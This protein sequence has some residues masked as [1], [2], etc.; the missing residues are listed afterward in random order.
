ME[1]SCIHILGIAPYEGMRTIML[2]AAE[3]YPNIHLDVAIGDLDEGV[4]IVQSVPEDYYDCIISRG[5]T[6]QRIRQVSNT[7][8]IEIKLSIYD[9][10]RSIKLAENYGGK[11]AVVGFPSIT[12][13]AHILCDLLRYKMDILTI[14]NREDVQPALSRLRADGYQM[15]VGDMVTHTIA[16][17]MGMDAFLITSGAEGL[18]SA[19]EQAITISEAFRRLRMENVVLRGIVQDDVSAVVLDRTGTVRYALPANPNAEL[20]TALRSRLKEIP[21]ERS[22]TF[23]YKKQHTLYSI[24]ARKRSLFD[25]ECTTFYCR[26]GHIPL[27][28]NS[29]GIRS[30]GKLECEHLFMNSFYSL[31][32]AMGEIDETV[33]ALARSRQSV[34]IYG[35]MGTGKEQIAKALYL[36]GTQTNMPFVVFNCKLMTEKSWSF[37]LNHPNSP[38][39]ES[40]GT[41]YFQHLDV[42]PTERLVQL[43]S[44]IQETGMG[45]RLRLIFSCT[46]SAMG[47]L[48]E[49]ARQ[50]IL[51]LGC[52]TVHMPALRARSDEI[53][54]LAS[55]YLNSLNQE[56]GKQISGF[57]PNAIAQLCHYRWPN[58]YT[59]FKHVLHE[60]AVL[61]DSNYIRSAL[62][63][64]LLAKEATLTGAPLVA[65]D[66]IPLTGTLEQITQAVI[67]QA[68]QAHGGNQSAA[69]RQLG[70]GRTTLWRYLSKR[71]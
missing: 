51:E 71:E 3:N 68:I 48:S 61:C 16:R 14:H 8:V 10:L 53:P 66:G 41:L 65:Q 50:F 34:L 57:E 52:L 7:P 63:A 13:P 24:E 37:L 11:Y 20:L 25:T 32:G 47:V 39:N 56:L 12:E 15:V 67:Q 6:A 33:T 55:L 49:E 30:Y 4:A 59:Q 36:R 42:L 54:S 17:Q 5:G 1:N 35:E 31:S 46:Y 38:F 23:Y 26:S 21:R 40:A 27:R 18:R 45:K 22:L 62:V 2:R 64:E 58:N 19:L 60:L 28:G 29:P 43:Q 44:V 70:I 69:A 9:V